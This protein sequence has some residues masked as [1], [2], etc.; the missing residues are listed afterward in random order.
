V[1]HGQVRDGRPGIRWCGLP[2]HEFRVLLLD[3]PK[4]RTSS[5]QGTV[6][7]RCDGPC[8][9]G[10]CRGTGAQGE[11]QHRDWRT[12]PTMDWTL[13]GND[14]DRPNAQRPC[15]R[16]KE[17]SVRDNFQFYAPAFNTR[18]HERNSLLQEDVAKTPS[19]SAQLR[20]A[21]PPQV[22]SLSYRSHFRRS[23]RVIRWKHPTWAWCQPIKFIPMP[24]DV[25]P[26]SC[27]SANWVTSTK[28]VTESRLA[29]IRACRTSG[30]FRERKSARHIQG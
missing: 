18:A 7:K 15:N 24:R 13:L 30:D 19:S 4:S 8:R 20:P 6:Q 11:R 2:A 27:R 14:L 26:D 1:R 23:K 17:N 29:E 21:L 9:T 3:Q 22:R 16:A 5:R 12:I 10:Q 28:R 25:R